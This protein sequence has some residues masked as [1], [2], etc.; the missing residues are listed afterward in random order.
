[1]LRVPRTRCDL[2]TSGRIP[3]LTT[4]EELQLLKGDSTGEFSIE[5]MDGVSFVAFSPSGHRIIAMSE[6]LRQ[7]DAVTGEY[8]ADYENVGVHGI[9]L[10]DDGMRVVARD[11]VRN[12]L[13][14]W[15]LPAKHQLVIMKG[16]LNVPRSV[17]HQCRN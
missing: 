7:W 9:A 6:G 2:T 10:T 5:H 14:T 12:E 1:L 3:N 17:D 13:R 8:V 16:T 15:V 4:G 11:V